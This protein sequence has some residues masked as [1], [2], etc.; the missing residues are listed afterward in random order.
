MRDALS[1]STIS[2]VIL[3]KSKYAGTVN[4]VLGYGTDEILVTIRKW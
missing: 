2:N 3:L 1:S 4:N